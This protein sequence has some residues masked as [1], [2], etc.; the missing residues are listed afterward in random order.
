VGLSAPRLRRLDAREEAQQVREVR[1]GG[2]H[3]RPRRHAGPRGLHAPQ[4]M[5]GRGEDVY[6][7]AACGYPAADARVMCC[8]AKPSSGKT[9]AKAER[10]TKCVDA[11]NGKIV[12]HAC[13]ASPSAPEACSFDATNSCAVLVV[14][15]TVNIPSN[16]QP[17]FGVSIGLCTAAEL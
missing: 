10:V 5:Q 3:R 1:Q 8:E 9:T 11:P 16:A 14:H 4:G 17:A 12:R 15:E 6:S 7:Q 13:S 2:D